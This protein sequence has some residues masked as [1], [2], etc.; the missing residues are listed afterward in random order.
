MQKYLHITESYACILKM[1]I[2]IVNL[3]VDLLKNVLIS[4]AICSTPKLSKY[5]IH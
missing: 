4:F 5:V 1:F 2:T 3:S